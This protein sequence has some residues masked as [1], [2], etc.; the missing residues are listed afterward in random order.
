MPVPIT[1]EPTSDRRLLRSLAFAAGMIG[2]NRSADRPQPVVWFELCAG[3]GVN[4]FTLNCRVT[5]DTETDSGAAIVTA[6]PGVVMP[7]Q[8]LTHRRR[9]P[10][11]SGTIESR[12][13]G[14]VADAAMSTEIGPPAP[15]VRD[16]RNCVVRV[17]TWFGKPSSESAR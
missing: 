1:N 12:C 14:R 11:K 7:F 13:A 17:E 9:P 15:S 6:L 16:S 8:L 5:A 10:M 3:G 4:E 2:A